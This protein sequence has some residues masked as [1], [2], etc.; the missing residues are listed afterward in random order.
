MTFRVSSYLTNIPTRKSADTNK[1]N[2]VSFINQ[3]NSWGVSFVILQ[4]YKV[5][6]TRLVLHKHLQPLTTL[7][8]RSLTETPTEL[9][10][11]A[12][13]RRKL[14]ANDWLSQKHSLSLSGLPSSLTCGR[15]RGGGW[16]LASKM[17]MY[18]A[19]DFTNWMCQTFFL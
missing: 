3:C 18:V 14:W 2:F 7:H 15:V 13:P 16:Y 8:D 12:R 5:L 6:H 10:K 4:P 1:R 11:W 9:R 19:G 17:R